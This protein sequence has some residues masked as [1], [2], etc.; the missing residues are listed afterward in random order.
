M[1]LSKPVIEQWYLR[2]PEEREKMEPFTGC[3]FHFEDHV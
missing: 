3:P 2:Y 1:H